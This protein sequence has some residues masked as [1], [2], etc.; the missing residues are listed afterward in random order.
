MLVIGTSHSQAV[1]QRTPNGKNEDI[2]SGRWFDWISKT[3]DLTTVKLARSGCSAE[4]Q[5]YAVYNYFSV[6]PD[7]RFDVCIVEGR[8]LQ[9][10]ASVPIENYDYTL[11]EPTSQFPDFEEWCRDLS[12]KK[13]VYFDWTDEYLKQK[14]TIE[15]LCIYDKISHLYPSFSD[16]FPQQMVDWF[17]EY[18]GSPLFAVQNWSTNLSMLKYLD[19]FCNK[20]FW[21]TFGSSADFIDINHPYNIMGWDLLKDYVLMEKERF[22]DIKISNPKEYPIRCHCGHLTEVGHKLIFEE[23]INPRLIELEVFK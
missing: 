10:S 20:T 8:G 15:N 21:F 19:N 3:Y 16:K 6:N 4:Q 12:P 17:L 18:Y 22:S 9:A 1:C 5:L 11:W 7:A 23:I 14:R 13:E 2:R